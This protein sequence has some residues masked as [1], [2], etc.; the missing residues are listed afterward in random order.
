MSSPSAPPPYHDAC[1]SQQFGVP[2]V[3]FKQPTGYSN[4]VAPGGHSSITAGGLRLDKAVRNGDRIIIDF[5]KVGCCPWDT[6]GLD[7]DCKNY[8]PQE[9]ND[10]GISGSM[11]CEWCEDL[12]KVQKKSPS[13]G[14]CLCI[15]CFPGFFVQSI[16]CA[17]FCPISANH[18]LKCLPCFYGDWYHGLDKWQR[19]VNA[20][21]NPKDMHLKLKTYKPHQKWVQ[22]T[23]TYSSVYI[24]YIFSNLPSKSM[25]NSYLSLYYIP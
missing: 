12:A 23:F 16:L 24:Y 7:P 18:P 10:K 9:L 13:V 2:D 21:L 15:F 20:V 8:V 17:T 6:V 3:T 5:E 1:D 4:K 14:G 25:V 22:F 19:K 11:W